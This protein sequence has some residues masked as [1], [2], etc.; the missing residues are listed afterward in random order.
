MVG[1]IFVRDSL[2]DRT[3]MKQNAHTQPQLVT[4]GYTQ[5]RLSIYAPFGALLPKICV[6]CATYLADSISA[7]TKKMYLSTQSQSVTFDIHLCDSCT[8]GGRRHS[9]FFCSYPDGYDFVVQFA[10][11]EVA[12]VWKE[13][14]TKQTKVSTAAAEEWIKQTESGDQTP[15]YDTLE[16]AMLFTPHVKILSEERFTPNT[17][18]WTPPANRTCFVATATMGDANHPSVR[19]LRDFRD[20]R[21]LSCW[22][23]RFA[24]RIYYHIGPGM[25]SVIAPHCLLRRISYQCFVRPAVWLARIFLKK[26]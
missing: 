22:T 16:K 14:L 7:T 21:L 3:T 1:K 5:F 13:V 19:L 2:G 26:E 12:A 18:K 15:E 6:G 8:Q 4:S 23:G 9:D 24:V 17:P 10:N 25:A 20:R 11:S